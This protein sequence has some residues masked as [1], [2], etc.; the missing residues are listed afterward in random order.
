MTVEEQGKFEELLAQ[1][2]GSISQLTAIALYLS[3]PLLDDLLEYAW[4]LLQ[5]HRGVEEES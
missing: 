5:E 4:K 1:R 2:K 3:D